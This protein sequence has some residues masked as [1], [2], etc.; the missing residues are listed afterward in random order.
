VCRKIVATAVR[1][2]NGSDEKLSL[3]NVS[4][5]RDW[6][7]AAEYADA[8]WR[9]LQQESIDDFIIATGETCTLREVMDAA[10]AAVGLRR[11][12]SRDD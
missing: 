4:I 1:I 11:Q 3:G 5:R 8:M 9:I 2:A 10:F 12:R 7:L 6:G